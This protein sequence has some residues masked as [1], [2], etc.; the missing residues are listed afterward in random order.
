MAG[1]VCAARARELGVVPRVLEKG[2][3]PG[4]SMLLSSCV[5]W[6]Y[7]T[8]QD[9]RREC[10]GG[11]EALQRLIVER[12][13]EGL[14]WLES[15]GAPVVWRETPNPRTTG[16]RFDP[17]GLT[18]V[19]VHA[20]GDVR[21]SEPFTFAEGPVVL[22]T[23]G[24][25]A[26]AELVA[27]YVTTEPVVVRANPWSTGDGLRAGLERGGALTTGMDEFYGRNMAD[28]DF[29]ED[30]YVRLAQLYA[31]HAVVVDD[32]GK[33]FLAGVPTWSETDVV[34]ATARQPGARAW[35]LLSQE[36]LA[37]ADVAGRVVAAREAGAPVLDASVLPFAAPAGIAVG[38]RVRA[39]IT[40][41]IGG[42]RVDDEA[43]VLRADGEPVDGVYAAGV[44]AGGVSTGGYASGLAQ[45]LV[46]G[47]VASESIARA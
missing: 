4:G 23:G 29:S 1:L 15:L 32:R 39:A 20:A 2:N 28:T 35:Y 22:A 16:M 31:R 14:I 5:I 12:L 40:H 24:F 6:R 43:R 17:R 38:V 47:L 45:A 18:D 27:R 7:Q 10:P 42:L 8:L 11:D 36:T 13:D 9:F 30:D 44:D 25:A 33:P 26:G 37:E 3:R 19:L 41:T 21:L 34:Q 46:L